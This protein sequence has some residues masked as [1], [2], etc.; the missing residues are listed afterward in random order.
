MES[1]SAQFGIVLV[2]AASAAE[3]EAI[4]RT[5]VQEK[6]AACVN[7]MPIRSIYTWQNEV[8][9][10]EEWQLVIKT[11]LS[12]FSRLEE[13]V[14]SLHSYEVPE[15]IALPILAGSPAYLAWM[16]EQTGGVGS[17]E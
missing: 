5:L 3:A 16:A 10:E 15:I 9:H 11:D 6:L 12:Q 8:H 17:G 13:R 2:T 7:L 4:A 1:A 14:R